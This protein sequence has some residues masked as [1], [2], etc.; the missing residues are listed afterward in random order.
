MWECF[1]YLMY[2]PAHSKM[3]IIRWL[4]AH[5]FKSRNR[6]WNQSPGANITFLQKR[7]NQWL[8]F[9]TVPQPP[10][11]WVKGALYR[12]SSSRGTKDGAPALWMPVLSV[13]CGKE[14]SHGRQRAVAWRGPCEPR[15]SWLEVTNQGSRSSRMFTGLPRKVLGRV[16]EYC[17]LKKCP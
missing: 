5:I 15:A 16:D 7:I 13:Q 1:I 14:T 3:H 6:N 4:T 10:G 12:Q 17:P 2:I 9:E 11:G 8:S